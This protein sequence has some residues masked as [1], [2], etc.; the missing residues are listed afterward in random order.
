MNNVSPTPKNVRLH[1]TWPDLVGESDREAVFGT[2]ESQ[3]S[4]EA[5]RF[6]EVGWN[7]VKLASFPRRSV[8]RDAQ[9]AEILIRQEE[10]IY[11]LDVIREA[12]EEDLEQ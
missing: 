6:A 7:A 1:N 4:H 12:I 11:V 9:K 10:M 2:G 3:V 5:D 8:P